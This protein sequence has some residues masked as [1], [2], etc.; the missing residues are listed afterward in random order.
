MSVQEVLQEVYDHLMDQVF[1]RSDD[2]RMTRAKRGC[3][4]E[5]DHYK[6]MAEVISGL[7]KD[8]QSPETA[9]EGF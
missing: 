8:Y 5:F 7:M 1:V 4:R 3:E 2:Y 6:E 9:R